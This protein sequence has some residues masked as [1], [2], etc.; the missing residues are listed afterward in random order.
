MVMQLAGAQLSGAVAQRGSAVLPGTGRSDLRRDVWPC[1]LLHC[2]SDGAGKVQLDV[3]SST[4]LH[5]IALPTR[6]T[7]GR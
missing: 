3:G 1:A 6:V 2:K 5:V 7:F 4:L